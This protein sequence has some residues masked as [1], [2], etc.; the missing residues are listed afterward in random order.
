MNF[1]K[2]YNL[3][4]LSLFFLL[5]CC[6]MSF[7]SYQHY[8]DLSDEG[9]AAY[10][11]LA[12]KNLITNQQWYYISNLYGTIFGQNLLSYRVLLFIKF[13]VE[14]ILICC[15]VFFYYN[16]GSQRLDTSIKTKI[17]LF[18]AVLCAQ[19]SLVLYAI[20][21][22]NS[23]AGFA[24]YMWATSFLIYL[25][26]NKSFW[27]YF[28]VSALNMCA[29]ALAFMSKAPTG[30]A[31]VLGGIILFPCCYYFINGKKGIVP[32]SACSVLGVTAGCV[33]Y[34]LLI[35]ADLD[36]VVSSYKATGG[37]GIYYLPKVLMR[38][39][40]DLVN[41]AFYL[42]LFC[43]PILAGLFYAE[44]SEKKYKN[45]VVLLLIVVGLSAVYFFSVSEVRLF[46]E[47]VYSKTVFG[48]PINK[49]ISTTIDHPRAKVMLYMCALCFSV[50]VYRFKCAGRIDQSLRKEIVLFVVVFFATLGMSAGTT[51]HLA[52]H[53]HN[54]AGLIAIV[55][56][57]LF[58]VCTGVGKRVKLF[59]GINVFFCATLCVA[60]QYSYNFKEYYRAPPLEEQTSLSNESVFLKGILID[61]ERAELIDRM[62][63]GLL[64]VGFDFSHDK[65]FIYPVS[66]GLP[67]AVGAKAYGSLWASEQTVD[68]TCRTFKSE[69]ISLNERVY[70]LRGGD[71]FLPIRECLE[72]HVQKSEN[73]VEIDLG[74]YN[75][76]R[77]GKRLNYYL[78]GPYLPISK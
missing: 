39:V 51:L 36:A 16:D 69:T 61:D 55:C 26:R 75:N 64:S 32:S 43:I 67:A 5:L 76:S 77:E 10:L 66:P 11:S 24:A 53:M 12:G 35:R 31:F 8:F 56:V 29:V 73:F 28:G 23:Y 1:L 3:I 78:E 21:S 9:L 18:S 37:S 59:L 34:Y 19:L 41:S 50:F 62:Q 4:L 14:S 58:L 40:R 7:V 30:M 45:N 38:H 65:I 2:K 72:M 44:H 25:S 63:D 20:P 57:V 22:Y 46:P 70:I 48:L 42:C 13:I 49:I 74:N 52:F 54:T 60:S 47:F 17:T 71:L 33:V 27:L 68:Y 15:G 6:A